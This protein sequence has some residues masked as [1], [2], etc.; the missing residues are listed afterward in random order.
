MTQ[1]Q[2]DVRKTDLVQALEATRGS[3]EQVKKIRAASRLMKIRPVDASM[4]SPT[5]SISGIRAS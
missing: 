2:A 5:S 4:R 1:E 3:L